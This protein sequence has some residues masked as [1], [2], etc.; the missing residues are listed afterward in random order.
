MSA[1]ERAKLLAFCTGSARVPATGFA[2]LMGYAGQIQKFRLQL[3]AGGAGRLPVASTCFNALK[4]HEY[5]SRHMLHG[6]LALALRE[7]DGF[8]EHAPAV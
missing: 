3:L 7:A 1:D 2:N 6:K 8:D 5:T 4:L